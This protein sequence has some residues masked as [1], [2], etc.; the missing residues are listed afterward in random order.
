M[1]TSRSCRNSSSILARSGGRS[2]RRS[3]RAFNVA[4]VAKSSIKAAAEVVECL[5]ER[6]CVQQLA[7]SWS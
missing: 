7:A 4:G 1:R 6:S 3:G 2:C 5:I